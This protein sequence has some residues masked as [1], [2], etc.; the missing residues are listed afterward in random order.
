MNDTIAKLEA[1]ESGIHSRVALLAG[2]GG[3]ILGAA[4][5]APARQPR[6][7]LNLNDPESIVAW[8]TVLPDRHDAY[9]AHK[10][11]VNP[12]FAPAINEARRHI[13]ARPELTRML[14][15]STARLLRHE[16]AMVSRSEGLS[17]LQL[18]HQE[19]STAS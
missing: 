11:R 15:Q 6:M 3:Q 19:L 5:L 12:E 16:A 18:R 13:A 14:D 8:W 9:L 4:W 17:S 1:Q 10:I 7:L 2:G